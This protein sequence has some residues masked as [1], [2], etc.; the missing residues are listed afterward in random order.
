MSTADLELELKRA[1]EPN[2]DLP[3]SNAL[4]LSIEDALAYRDAGNIPDELDRSLRLVLMVHDPAE[5]SYLQEKRL[6]FEPD[7]HDAPSWRRDGSRPVNV[8]PIRTDRGDTVAAMAGGWWNDPD[9]A[10][11]EDEWSRTGRVADMT[12][13]AEYR[14]FIY[15]TVLSLRTAD[16]EV[17]VDS[18]LASIAR[19]LPPSDVE[20]IGLA[21]RKE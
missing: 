20:R 13:P 16:K 3:A 4:A 18:V 1:R 11:L 2:L 21:L 9:L 17:S 19:W 7:F 6:E 14:S 12:V 8:V 15:K 10:R 5:L